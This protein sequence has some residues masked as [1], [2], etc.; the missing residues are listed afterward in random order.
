VREDRE[1]DGITLATW[2]YQWQ[3]HRIWGATAKI[4]QEF[5]KQIK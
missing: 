5:I 2:E 3:E 4:I 1:I